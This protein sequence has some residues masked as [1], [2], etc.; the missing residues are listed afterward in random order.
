MLDAMTTRPARTADAAVSARGPSRLR[1]RL[2]TLAGAFRSHGPAGVIV[3]VAGRLPRRLMAVEW[4]EVREVVMPGDA[5]ERP[6]PET[7]R[8]GPEDVDGLAAVGHVGADEARARLAAGDVAYLATDGGVPVAYVWF[9]AGRW[10]EGDVEYV[11]GEGERWG[12]DL[13][14][15]P[16]HRGRRVAAALMVAVGEA[17]PA[18]GVHRTLAVIDYLNE[19]S[20]RAARHYD[21]RPVMACVTVAAA[22][23]VALHE[24]KA[25]GGGG[26]WSFARRRRGIVRATPASR[27]AGPL[28]TAPGA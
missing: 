24:R 2:A 28:T 6:W 18:D 12:Y 7:R 13:Y 17:M 1:R 11:L 16:G 3:A 23:F 27:L 9:R 26:S 21:G 8:A 15:A 22:G 14:V 25:G 10:R 19:S 20:R 5:T 4:Y